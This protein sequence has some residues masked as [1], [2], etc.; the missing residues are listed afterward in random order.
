MIK[1]QLRFLVFLIPIFL[2]IGINLSIDSA[3]LYH[4]DYLNSVSDALAEGK[5]VQN[6]SNFSKRILHKK[7]I[8][9]SESM[10]DVLVLGSSRSMQICKEMFPGKTFTNH[11]VTN[12][13]TYDMFAFLQLY[14]NKYQRLPQH[15]I[16]CIDQYYLG[17]QFDSK[18]W[19][20]NS[21]EVLKFARLNG[22]SR[23]GMNLL[24]YQK[25]KINELLSTKYLIENATASATDWLS[26]TTLDSALYTQFPDGSFS[27]PLRY[28]NRSA[29]KVN[30]AANAYTF[31]SHD[32]Y[33]N[34]IDSTRQNL[35]SDLFT[36]LSKQKVKVLVYTAP[37]HPLTYSI[38]IN[39]YKG[40][41]K[42]DSV[43]HKM[44]LEHGFLAFGSSNPHKLGLNESDFYDG[45]HMKR[46]SIIRLWEKNKINKRFLSY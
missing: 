36:W 7:R 11:S 28:V 17:D 4:H 9:K 43:L 27:R 10:P 34:T 3:H 30:Q 39:N 22:F 16:L 19:Y 20:I 45:T 26:S 29:D 37:Y 1:V 14:K 25:G 2:M 5:Y 24:N 41:L 46:T 42:A 21:S 31:L 15:I 44:A 23:P 18:L 12:C 35:V 6:L 13:Y 33:F 38:T 8:Q 32:E 40:I